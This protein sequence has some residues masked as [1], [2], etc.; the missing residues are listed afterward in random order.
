MFPVLLI[1]LSIDKLDGIEKFKM[2]KAK[3][4]PNIESPLILMPAL[5]MFSQVFILIP[6]SLL[7][8]LL[9]QF[10]INCTCMVYFELTKTI[11]FD[12][13]LLLGLL[14]ELVIL[15]KALK[16]FCHARKQLLH[17]HFSHHY[18]IISPNNL[19]LINH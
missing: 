3:N 14:Q 4:K 8:I 18:K 5:R 12:I 9:D 11:Y 17:P 13:V 10:R 19:S 2:N 6:R 16:L 7:E 15:M 1:L